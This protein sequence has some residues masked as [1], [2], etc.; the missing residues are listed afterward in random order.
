MIT[1]AS[2]FFAAGR[3]TPRYFRQN[4]RRRRLPSSGTISA[5]PRISTA[6]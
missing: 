6:V 2:S 4:S 5:V 3:S 1:R